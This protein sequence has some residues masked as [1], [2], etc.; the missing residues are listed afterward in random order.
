MSGRLTLTIF[1]PG[2]QLKG[3]DNFELYNPKDPRG[4]TE[5]IQKAKHLPLDVCTFSEP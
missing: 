3:D 5:R 4:Y 2:G 1:G